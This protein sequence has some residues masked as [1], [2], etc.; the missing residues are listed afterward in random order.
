MQKIF[1][2]EKKGISYHVFRFNGHSNDDNYS[3]I[4]DVGALET[5]ESAVSQGANVIVNIS[6]GN[7]AAALMK[8]GLQYNIDKPLEE[9]VKVVHIICP[10]NSEMEQGLT[11]YFPD[12]NAKYSIPY[13]CDE[14]LKKWLT[15]EDRVSIARKAIEHEQDTNFKVKGV[16]DATHFIPNEYMRQAEEILLQK[17]NGKYLDYLAI[18]VGTGKGFISFYRALNNLKS[19]GIEINT[20]L[21][22]IVPEGEN[23]IYNTFVFQHYE[24]GTIENVINN[25][26]PKSKADKLSCPGTDLLEELKK[27]KA[28][29]HK[30]IQVDDSH[31]TKANNESARLGRKYKSE[32]RLEDSASVGFITADY[33]TINKLLAKDAPQVKIKEGDNVGIFVTGMGLY[34][35]PSW[36]LKAMR[37][38]RMLRGLK[39]GM[40]YALIVGVAGAAGWHT[41][42]SI[43]RFEQTDYG[44]KITLLLGNY[45][46][47]KLMIEALFD[48]LGK[49]PEGQRPSG[50]ILLGLKSEQLDAVLKRYIELANEKEQELLRESRVYIKPDTARINEAK[51]LLEGH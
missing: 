31:I 46:R 49:I 21:I 18:P 8:E 24:N 26:D 40:V 4:K 30:F 16:V 35:T 48:V 28:E 20:K 42:N 22:G 2:F 43:A 51:R 7:N 23:P 15:V 44:K 37:K 45:Q 47:D 50:N 33:K 3:T 34:A 25:F 6:S 10:G 14:M 39:K 12:S 17:T 41:Y 29:G 38:E 13:V 36:E 32:L 1:D 5:I 19:K 9:R 27:A 11:A